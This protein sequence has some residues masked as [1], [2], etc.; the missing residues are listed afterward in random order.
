MKLFV[1]YIGGTHP[2][3]FIELHDYRFIIANTIED[4]YQE[5]K[6]TWW[7]TPE[8]LHLDAWG[9]LEYVDGYKIKISDKPSP[10][11][12]MNLYF[13]NL[14]GYDSKLFTELHKDVFVVAENE[15]KAKVKALK[16]ILNWESHHRDYLHEVE[17]VVNV[18]ET[19]ANSKFY[20]VLEPVDNEMKF[21]FT[22][23]YVPIGKNF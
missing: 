15:S 5:L 4:T 13:V 1:I 21:N 17:S 9:V 19:I 23:K 16:Q 20:L 18:S 11:T 3:A 7:G 6:D 22:C 2:K 12:E 8:S 14:G 10:E